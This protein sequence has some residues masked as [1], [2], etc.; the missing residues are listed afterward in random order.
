MSETSEKFNLFD[1]TSTLDNF[2]DEIDISQTK[3]ANKAT[4]LQQLITHLEYRLHGYMWRD[5]GEKFYYV[6]TALAG[7]DLIQKLMLLMQ[8]FSREIILISKKDVHTWSKQVMRT[9]INVASLLTRE[10]DSDIKTIREIWRSI[11]NLFFNIGDI[12]CSGNSRS[13]LEGYLNIHDK[14]GGPDNNNSGGGD[15]V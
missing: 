6:G 7:A 15:N 13:F 4:E 5:N 14:L 3:L 8:P 12:I 11:S 2:G 1:N 9:R 10:L